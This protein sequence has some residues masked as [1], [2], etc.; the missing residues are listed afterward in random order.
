MRRLMDVYSG[1]GGASRLHVAG[2]CAAVLI[3]GAGCGSDGGP[4][5]PPPPPP[6][7]TVSG[8]SLTSASPGDTLLVTGN[9]F[10]PVPTSNRVKF[11]NATAEVFPF[12]AA[13]TEL[14]AVVPENAISGPVTVASRGVAQSGSSPSLQITRGA[15]DVWIFG[16]AGAGSALSLETP[17]GSQY[18]LIPYAANSA[19]PFSQVHS[20]AFSE[21]VVLA[22]VVAADAPGLR[23]NFERERWKQMD[24]L[25]A[26]L[27]RSRLPEFDS[28]RSTPAAGQFRLFETFFVLNSADPDIDITDADNFTTVTAELRYTGNHSVIYS[29][30][31]TLTTGNLTQTDMRA[32][33]GAF[34]NQIQP[35]NTVKFGAPSDIDDSNKVIILITPVVNR[36]T[37]PASPSFIGGFFHPGDLLPGAVDEGASN[38]AEIFYVLAADTGAF[39]GNRF[40]LPFVRQEN[41]KTIAHEHQHLISFA[42][43]VFK[44]GGKVQAFWLEEGMSHMAED[45]SG[46]NSSNV[47]RANEYLLDPGETSLEDAGAPIT[48]RGAAYLFLRLLGDR[49]GEDIFFAI[50]NGDCVGRPCIESVTGVD[51]Y[52]TVGEF[53]AALYLSGTGITADNRFNYSSIDLDNFTSVMVTGRNLGDS[54]GGTVKLSSGDLFLLGNP[55]VNPHSY[56]I[57]AGADAG[58]RVVVVRT[59]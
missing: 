17:P 3:A 8:L 41:V 46:T 59:Q 25:I 22:D 52:Q 14:R 33:A 5:E 34:D 11:N 51:F 44:Q 49:F 36:M 16:N 12:A 53:L 42:V 9:N 47:D 13:A 39:W 30:I 43:R 37:P 56:V 28:S 19:A 54:F 45:F 35:T 4:V 48:Q 29:D 15:G 38:G 27:D 10:S 7:P 58:L 32:F 20:Y 55:T 26:G 24:R 57:S 23:E 6:P 18:L 31:D 1:Y 21:P 50:V 40:S 2:V